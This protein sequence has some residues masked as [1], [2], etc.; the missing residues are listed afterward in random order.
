MLKFKDLIE[1]GRTEE[2]AIFITNSP[3]Y[4]GI[5][6]VNL[7][8]VGNFENSVKSARLS[9]QRWESMECGEDEYYGR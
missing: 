7:E 1:I 4:K 5:K 2:S 9:P 6:K 8:K 3:L